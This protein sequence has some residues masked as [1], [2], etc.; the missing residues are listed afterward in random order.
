MALWEV[1]SDR[2][3]YTATTGGF[4]TDAS[5]GLIPGLETKPI[6]T[7]TNPSVGT[8]FEDIWDAGGLLT[9]PTSAE[10]WELVSDDANDTS[11]GTG[12]RTAL[13]VSLDASYVEQLQ[14]V[15]LNGTTPVAL[16]G[17]HIRTIRTTGISA[18]SGEANAGTIT[19]RVASAGAT[20]QQIRPAE[21]T[22][23][24][25]FY[26]TPANRITLIYQTFADIPKGEDMEVR[27]RVRLDSATPI[28]LTGGT[29]SLYQNN[30]VFP[31]KT[32]GVFGEKTDFWL[33]AKST[34]ASI[35][36]TAGFEVMEID[37]TAFA[38]D[39]SAVMQELVV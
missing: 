3:V 15:T 4:F 24:S 25:S 2:G 28:Q 33:Q 7:G 6:V 29:L 26:T 31:L 5:L 21:G 19:L 37:E 23:F 32:L 10:T 18:G 34:N 17:T 39:V 20:R 13:V 14:V 8:S 16:T 22:S 36:V 27:S 35:T 1:P 30:L 38:G 12:L 9:W 11:A